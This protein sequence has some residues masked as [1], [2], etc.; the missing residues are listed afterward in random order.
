V[1]RTATLLNLRTWARQLSDT[2]NDDSIT[3]TELTALANRHYP[4]VYDLL[5]EAGPPEFYASSTTVSVVASTIPYALASDFRALLGVY[6]HE[7]SDERRPLM[8]MPEG[9]RGQ[10]KAPSQSVT[11]TL[12]YIPAASTLSSGSDTVDGV[13]GWE[14]LIVCRMAR[15]VMTKLEKDPSI[16]MATAA[17][18]ESRIKHRSKNRD[19]GQPRR[20]VDLDEAYVTA[21]WGWTGASK[22][23]CYRLRAGNIEF[24]E[25]LWGYP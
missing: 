6:V 3:D 8:P 13:S 5:I 2:E 18:L 17:A 25:P 9:A 20:I 12:E 11:V 16:P 14:E 1:A 24:Y 21:P 7:S 10:F 15:D 4:E 23:G 22:L 19:R